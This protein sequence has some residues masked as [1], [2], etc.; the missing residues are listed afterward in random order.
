MKRLLTLV[1][2]TFIL[3]LI[4]STALADGHTATVA[5][6]IEMSKKAAEAILKDQ[7]AALADISRKDGPFVWKDSYVF[8]MDLKG[9]MLAHPMKPGLMKMDSLLSTPDKNPTEPKMLFVDLVVTAGTAG[10]GWVE[11]M[12]P[13]PG[14]TEPSIKE[15]YV[16]R[17][18]GTSMFTAAGIYR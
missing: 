12:W 14:S 8:V 10:E 9:K 18:P 11:Y 7:D 17:V 15:T 4:S 3:T 6:C 13:K 16:Y 2:A 5:E 1:L